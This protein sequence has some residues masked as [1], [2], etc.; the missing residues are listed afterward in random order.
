M[1]Y[2]EYVEYA[3]NLFEKR[4][5]DLQKLLRN[6]Y[7]VGADS[8]SARFFSSIGKGSPLPSPNPLII[9]IKKR[10]FEHL[11]EQPLCFGVL[12][13][14]IPLHTPNK[15]AVRVAPEQPIILKSFWKGSGKTFFQKGFPNVLLTYSYPFI[16]R[17]RASLMMSST[18]RAVTSR[19]LRA[20]CA[21]LRE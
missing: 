9:Q 19:P 4:F 10:L 15:K 20:D 13:G 21:S 12:G 16:S 3:K 17:L 11:P 1:E 5:L 18:E 2:V 6:H 14:E 8:I 7:I